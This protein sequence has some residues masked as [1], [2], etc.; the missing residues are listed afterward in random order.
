MRGRSLGRA[1]ALQYK[2]KEA[3]AEFTQALSLSNRNLRE[4]AFA[5]SSAGFL[6]QRQEA[7]RL[8]Q[9]LI[10]VSRKHYVAPYLP[11]FV[12][13]NLGETDRA[14]EYFEK[15]FQEKSISPWPLRDPPD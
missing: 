3:A 1:Y 5:A 9:E 15:A 10:Q 11:A 8:L 4:V 7:Q 12:Y 2:G 14:F 13:A 6:G